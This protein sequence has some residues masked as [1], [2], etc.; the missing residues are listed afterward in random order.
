MCARE[1]REGGEGE[2]EGRR[3]GVALSI[4]PPAC[5]RDMV[6]VRERHTVLCECQADSQL[7]IC[8]LGCATEL[9]GSIYAR[10]NMAFEEMASDKVLSMNGWSAF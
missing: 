3:E 1:E 6:C 5:R 4:H 10:P 8:F 2:E 9:C 7:M